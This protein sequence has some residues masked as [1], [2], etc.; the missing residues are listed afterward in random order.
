MPES[1]KLKRFRPARPDD[2]DAILDLLVD[3]N[4]KIGAVYGIPADAESTIKTVL[5]IIHRGVC[6]VGNHACA[7]GFIYPYPW[8]EQ[9]KVGLLLFWNYTRPSGVHVF[10]AM[11]E[12]FRELGATHLNCA[13]HFPDNRLA[14][15]YAR[16]GLRAAEIQHISP[17]ATMRLHRTSQPKATHVLT[18]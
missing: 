6:L 14:R 4:R 12:R 16:F 8:N 11:A 10:G 17:L 3:M 9:A 7:G 18:G 15:W 1:S 5:H 2:L 13:S